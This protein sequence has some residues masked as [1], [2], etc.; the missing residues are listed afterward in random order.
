MSEWMD[1]VF[2]DR[3]ALGRRVRDGMPSAAG[4]LSDLEG[5]GADRKEQKQEEV[6]FESSLIGGSRIVLRAPD[7]VGVNLHAVEPNLSAPGRPM[8]AVALVRAPARNLFFSTSPDGARS[9]QGLRSITRSDGS[10]EAS[11]GLRRRELPTPCE[12]AS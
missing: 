1:F 12:V 9:N 6:P 8:L 11:E 5:R 2:S 7:R 4:E 3:A 10:V